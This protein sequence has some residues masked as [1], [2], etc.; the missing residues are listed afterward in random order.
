MYL[1]AYKGK[2]VATDESLELTEYG[3]GTPTAPYGAPRFVCNTLNEMEKTLED[4]ADF[5]DEDGTIPGW[6]TPPY[7]KKP[8]PVPSGLS[9]NVLVKLVDTT[10]FV[11]VK[12]YDRAHGSHGR[13]LI[14]KNA[15]QELI[16]APVGTEKYESDC[17]DYVKIN[18]LENALHFSFTWLNTY[19]DNSVR[20][21]RQDITVPI[22]NVRYVLEFSSEQEYL[23]IPARPVT[24]VV[25]SPT[26]QKM[27]G[28]IAKDKRLRRAFSKAM[29]DCFNWTGD[30]ITLHK[31]GQNSFFFTT[32]SGF[33]KCG[34]LI[35]HEGERNGHPYIYYSVHT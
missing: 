25:P 19:G 12:T 34:G 16:K 4:L 35:L 28:R 15:L 8:K 17:G 26:S 2:F 23:Y 32:R 6:E 1:Y 31:D 13:F 5:Y 11:G 18:R 22:K 20:G 30:V 3:D 27:I 10:L 9:P 21:F 24:A 14:S 33:P 29:R 7:Y